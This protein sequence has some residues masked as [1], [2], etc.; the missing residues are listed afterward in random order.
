MGFP[1]VLFNL[2]PGMGAYSLLSRKI[3]P[4]KAEQLISNGRL[5]SAEEMLKL[6]VIDILVEDGLGESAVYGYINKENRSSNAFQAIR[7]VKD[8]VNPITWEELKSIVDIWVDAALKLS[9]RDLR[10]MERLVSR[11]KNIN[12]HTA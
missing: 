10:M 4:A 12:T 9:N 11:Q 8:Y 3:G 2:F 6:G 1:E 5:Y 7:K